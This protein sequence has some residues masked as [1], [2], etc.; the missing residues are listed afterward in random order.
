MNI[1]DKIIDCLYETDSKAIV[2]DGLDEA[3]VG[4]AT[5]FQNQ[6]PVVAY[7]VALIISILMSRDEMTE[8]EAIEFFNFNIAGLGVEGSPVFIHTDNII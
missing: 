2:L 3:I 8:E 1:K 4:M 7:S 6:E 5:S